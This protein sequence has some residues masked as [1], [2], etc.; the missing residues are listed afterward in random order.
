MRAQSDTFTLLPTAPAYK[1]DMS[2]CILL[3]I[4][5][6]LCGECHTISLKRWAS[7][8]PGS[9]WWIV[10]VPDKTTW[11]IYFLWQLQCC[12]FWFPMWCDADADGKRFCPSCTC[13]ISQTWY[14]SNL[15]HKQ[16]FQNFNIDPKKRVIRNISDFGYWIVNIS[17]HRIGRIS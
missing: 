15:L 6:L 4:A 12:R 7:I 17:I 3:K 10:H 16:I 14:L 9:F 5:E 8:T 2:T 11:I 13:P 1:S